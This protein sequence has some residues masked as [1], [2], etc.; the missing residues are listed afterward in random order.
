LT[1]LISG[2]YSAGDCSTVQFDCTTYNYMMYQ[3]FSLHAHLANV[4][5]RARTVMVK[6]IVLMVQMKKWTAW[7]V[8]KLLDKWV[9]APVSYLVYL[10]FKLQPRDWLS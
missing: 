1:N 5:S 9:N 6:R 4:L 3:N 8:R 2:V 7:K 10:G